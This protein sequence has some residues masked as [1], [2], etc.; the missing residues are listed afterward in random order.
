MKTR[1]KKKSQCH[2]S[3]YHNCIPIYI[4]NAHLQSR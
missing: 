2:S 3:R 1:V 4:C